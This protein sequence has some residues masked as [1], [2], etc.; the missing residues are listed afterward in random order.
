[1]RAGACTIVPK[2]DS[3]LKKSAGDAWSVAGLTRE[4][5]DV[6]STAPGGGPAYGGTPSD[7]GLGRLVAELHGRGLA[8][9]LYPFVMM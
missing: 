4:T 3:A 5:A 6:V 1:L 9:V 7:A 8:V 2:V